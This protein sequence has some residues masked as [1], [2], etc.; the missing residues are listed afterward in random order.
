MSAPPSR[1]GRQGGPPPLAPALAYSA[2]IIAAAAVA[3]A[4]PWPATSA[5]G[6]LSYARAHTGL[7]HAEA[8]LAFAAAVPLAIWTATI[9]RRLRTLGVTAPGAVIGLAG[10]IL[11]AASI[12]VSGLVTWTLAE[13]AA[14]ASPALARALADLGFAAGAVGSVV[15]L[16]LLIAGVAVPS[17]ILG[18]TPRWLA[19]TGL[20]IAVAGML[21]T[22]TLVASALNPVLAV[23]Q[24]GA[25]AWLVVVSLMLPASRH[26]LRARPALRSAA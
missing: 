21:S 16:A 3:A 13:T 8:F 1:P 25:L 22:L 10:G 17:L 18:L 12:A 23:A 15:P 11:A 9:Y 20:V 7:L 4:G 2:L 14:D 24:F 5:A 6:A 19:W 26:Q